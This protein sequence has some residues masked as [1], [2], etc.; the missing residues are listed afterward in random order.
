MHFEYSINN[1]FLSKTLAVNFRDRYSKEYD[2]CRGLKYERGT[3]NR[4]RVRVPFVFYN[5]FSTGISSYT[6]TLSTSKNTLV[7]LIR[8][9]L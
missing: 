3:T 8:G 7:M 6:C 4:F 9:T 1:L 2:I 5:W